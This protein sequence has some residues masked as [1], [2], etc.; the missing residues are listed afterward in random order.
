MRSEWISAL[1]ITLLQPFPL[2]DIKR[3]ETQGVKQEREREREKGGGGNLFQLSIEIE[4]RL[5]MLFQCS[6]LP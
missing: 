5:M 2:S 3:E 4:M 6:Q 1:I